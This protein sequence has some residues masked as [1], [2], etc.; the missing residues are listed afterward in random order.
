LLLLEFVGEALQIPV[1]FSAD[2]VSGALSVDWG[3]RRG[4]AISSN[5]KYI[6]LIT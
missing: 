2:Q 6:L 5:T 1:I 4:D 3:K